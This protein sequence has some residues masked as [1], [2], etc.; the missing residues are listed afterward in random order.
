MNVLV[1]FNARGRNSS[2]EHLVY[3]QHHYLIKIFGHLTRQQTAQL[4]LQL[5]AK[6]ILSDVL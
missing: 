5:A 1:D 4:V 2:L 6:S 3:Q